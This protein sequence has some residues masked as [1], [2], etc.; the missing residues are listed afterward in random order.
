[1]KK[2]KTYTAIITS[3]LVLSSCH[4]LKGDSATRINHA[5]VVNSGEAREG[6]VNQLGQNCSK[7]FFIVGATRVLNPNKNGENIVTSSRGF[8]NSKPF[9]DPKFSPYQYLG[10]EGRTNGGVNPPASYDKPIHVAFFEEAQVTNALSS[11]EKLDLR[12]AKTIQSGH[13]VVTKQTVTGKD[14]KGKEIVS[15][16]NETTT[17]F[18]V[19]LDTRRT[20]ASNLYDGSSAHAHTEESLLAAT[21]RAGDFG[22][23]PFNVFEFG[24]EA[25]GLG[26]FDVPT[27][28]YDKEH[29]IQN[30]YTVKQGSVLDI[31]IRPSGAKPSQAQNHYLR[32]S[33]SQIN[34]GPRSAIAKTNHIVKDDGSAKVSLPVD[35]SLPTGLY[36]ISI[37]RAYLYTP[38]VGNDTLCIEAVAGAQTYLQVD[39][40]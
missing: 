2:I 25:L 37:N 29:P 26:T 7:G 31:A 40:Q 20:S 36:N 10:I 13:A 23:A 30:K 33:V 8:L 5:A 9:S 14:E 4:A 28:I 15:E 27:D 22:L 21:N 3:A 39:P 16:Q 17:A 32:V 1:M 12:N 35:A 19:G 18:N 38:K 6:L 34:P 11:R 24:N